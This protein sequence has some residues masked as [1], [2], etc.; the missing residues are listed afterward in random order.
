MKEYTTQKF[1]SYFIRRFR[2]SP[3]TPHSFKEN[4]LCCILFITIKIIFEIIFFIFTRQLR[5]SPPLLVGYC[6]RLH[7]SSIT[8]IAFIPRSSIKNNFECD[9][10]LVEPILKT[11]Q[12]IFFSTFHSIV[13]VVALT[14]SCPF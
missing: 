10:N 4:I 14:Q 5:L 9:F 7:S 11:K 2:L 13:H 6:C 12:S 1:S 8:A 3:F